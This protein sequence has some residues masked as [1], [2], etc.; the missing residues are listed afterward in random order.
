M[1]QS[2]RNITL[3]KFVSM[4]IQSGVII[5]ADTFLRESVI[6]GAT[7]ELHAGRLNSRGRRGDRKT[8]CETKTTTTRASTEE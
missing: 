3:H 2:W 6:S 1:R 5:M 7:R 4:Q 8:V